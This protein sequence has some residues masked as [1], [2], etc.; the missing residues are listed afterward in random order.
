MAIQGDNAP[1]DLAHLESPP[2]NSSTSWCA[3]STSQDHMTSCFSLLQYSWHPPP[4]KGPELQRSLYKAW[5]S[6]H[7]GN[8][9]ARWLHSCMKGRVCANGCVGTSTSSTTLLQQCKEIRLCK[10][11]RPELPS[12]LAF[13]NIPFVLFSNIL[14]S[15]A[16]DRRISPL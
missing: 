6:Q 4:L 2:D 7:N 13:T 5:R 10:P 12:S 16:T 14:I 15:P 9:L 8:T 3:M 1:V 11:Y